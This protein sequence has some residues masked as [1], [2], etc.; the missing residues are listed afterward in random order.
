MAGRAF[1][2]AVRDISIDRRH[3][4]LGLASTQAR[5]TGHP[6]RVDIY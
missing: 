2:K 3:D 6:G 4:T 5:P 1:H